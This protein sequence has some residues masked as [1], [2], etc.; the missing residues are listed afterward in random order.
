MLDAWRGSSFRSDGCSS[1][2]GKSPRDMIFSR[3]NST[4]CCTKALCK[5]STPTFL[6]SPYLCLSIQLYNKQKTARPLEQ[7]M[8][9]PKPRIC[10][11]WP[12]PSLMYV[13]TGKDH[14]SYLW[15]RKS[16]FPATFQG[17]YVS[18][19]VGMF[20]PKSRQVRLDLANSVTCSTCRSQVA[21]LFL[22]GWSGNGDLTLFAG[23]GVCR[24]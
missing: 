16:I 12:L 18:S 15:K 23:G 2:W 3:E 17:S 7:N 22:V 9:K 6:L 21:Q 10:H 4:T 14:T 13:G 19:L 8:L 11:E 20:P 1:L 5:N 24:K